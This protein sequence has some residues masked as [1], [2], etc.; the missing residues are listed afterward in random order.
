[1]TLH[2]LN[3]SAANR[4]L[5]SQLSE[6]IDASDC[7]LLIEDGTYHCQTAQQNNTAWTSTAETVYVL[8]EDAEARGVTIPDNFVAI[9]YKGFV[10]LSTQASK[11]ISWY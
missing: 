3:K 11:V 7:V 8:R 4:A 6:V 5:N 10:S 9:D 2:L 1:M